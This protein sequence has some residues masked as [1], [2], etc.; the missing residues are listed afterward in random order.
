MPVIEKRKRTDFATLGYRTLEPVTQTLPVRAWVLGD[1]REYFFQEV[2]RRDHPLKTSETLKKYSDAKSVD[3]MTNA[4]EEIEK[5]MIRFELR[6]S[7]I[8]YEQR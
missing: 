8:R 6:N 4:T 3:A 7:Q 1:T 5:K 2:T